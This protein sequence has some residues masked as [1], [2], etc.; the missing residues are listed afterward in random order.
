MAPFLTTH[1]GDPEALHDWARAPA[2]A[3]TD[4][5]DAV[6]ALIGAD[7]LAGSVVF[8]SGDVESRNLAVK[9]TIAAARGATGL[10][11]SVVDHPAVVATHRTLERAGHRISLVPVDR[12]GRV[13]PAT[14]AAALD[15]DTALVTIGHGQAE[16]GAVADVPALVAAVRDR[17]PDAV[18]HLDACTTAGVLPVHAA[19]WD[20]DV[21]STGGASMG[22]PRWVGAVWVREG[23][24][25]HPLIEG[26]VNEHGKRG[27][28]QDV[29]AIAGMGRAAHI[30]AGTMATRRTHLDDLSARLAAALLAV[31]GVRLNGPPVGERLPGHVQ[32]SVDGAESEAL[33]LLLATLGVACAPGSACSASGKA[34][35][36]LE[37]IGLVPPETHSAVLFTLSPTTTAAEVDLAGERFGD[38]VARLR[39][40]GPSERTG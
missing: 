4:A 36:V 30:A 11:A 26:G 17:R 15:D 10:V 31:D 33:T 37:A 8:T 14:L 28:R 32:V 18:V 9:G 24:R 12:T 1:F 35:P 27:G 38:A 25:L 40:M 6:T 16:I 3:L 13:E 22:A 34:A 39:A 20:V 23:T 19:D 2:D 29:P 5:R 21:V 7:A